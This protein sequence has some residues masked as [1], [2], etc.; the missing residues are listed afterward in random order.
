MSYASLARVGGPSYWRAVGKMPRSV[1]FMAK[2]KPESPKYFHFLPST[3]LLGVE[4]YAFFEI[5]REVFKSS[6]NQ[7]ENE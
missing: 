4:N 1:P 3:P 2:E 7:E 5:W 6:T